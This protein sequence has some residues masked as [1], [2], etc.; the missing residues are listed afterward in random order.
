MAPSLQ[1]PPFNLKVNVWNDKIH[2][3]LKQVHFLSHLAYL[4]DYNIML[5]LILRK[6]S[7]IVGHGHKAYDTILWFVLIIFFIFYNLIY[8]TT[9][10]VFTYQTPG[11]QEGWELFISSGASLITVKIWVW[12]ANCC[13]LNTLKLQTTRPFPQQCLIIKCFYCPNFEQKLIS[14]KSKHM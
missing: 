3:H 7:N 11:K 9:N 4:Y 1:V 6:N 13:G 10:F 14:N 2:T 12:N 5:Y 8:V